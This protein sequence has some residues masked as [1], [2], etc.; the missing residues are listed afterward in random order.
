MAG[1]KTEPLVLLPGFL[2]DAGLFRPQVEALSGD[3]PVTVAPTAGGER[4]EEI[5]SSL[6]GVLPGRIALL[7]HG[8]GGVVA[9]E[10]ARRAPERIARIALIAATPLAGTPHE[11]AALEARIVAARSG[12]LSDALE[13]EVPAAAL[14]PGA[15]RGPVMAAL[16]EMAKR[17][18]G[19]GYVRQLRAFQRRKDQQAVL[20]RLGRPTLILCGAHDTLVPVKRHSFM[21][22]MVP[23]ATL[24]VI[25]DAGH[26]PTLETPDAVTRAIREWMGLPL[27]LG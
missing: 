18:G 10:L 25:D 12:R 2:A 9:L 13:A 21:A 16:R 7:G 27:V 15:G 8:F 24:E 11:S 22:E 1:Q 3:I 23:G 6:L 17:T 19:P 5:A 4:V 14:A 20:H 26:L